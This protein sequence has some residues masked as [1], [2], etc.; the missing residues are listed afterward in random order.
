MGEIPYDVRSEIVSFLPTD[1]LNYAQPTMRLTNEEL[2]IE[3][4]NLGLDPLALVIETRKKQE[5]QRHLR[6]TKVYKLVE[7]LYSSGAWQIKRSSYESNMV[8]SE[9]SLL[10]KE[11]NAIWYN[12]LDGWLIE[13]PDLSDGVSLF[14][15][16]VDIE[17]MFYSDRKVVK[18]THDSIAA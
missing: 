3:M 6:T 1:A 4:R 17:E 16:I 15:A 12:L 8:G 7:L 14:D 18:K 9:T 13:D 10:E 11:L 5:R 2:L